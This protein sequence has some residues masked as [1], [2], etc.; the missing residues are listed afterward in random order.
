MAISSSKGEVDFV[1]R[2]ANGQLSGIYDKKFSD[3]SV[4]KMVEKKNHGL[5]KVASMTL[6]D[7]LD[8]HDA[9]TVI[10]YLN[11]DTEG[12]EWEILRV[13][14]FSKYTFR[15]ITVEHN[16]YDGNNFDPACKVKKDNIQKLLESK[17]YKLDKSVKA[18]DWYIY[19][20]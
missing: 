6:E 15:T 1:A 18:D 5:I 8:K 19:V 7:L 4:R 3:V 14:D 11:I 16:Y 13:F 10:D 20:G 2:G 12:A 17:G 9:P